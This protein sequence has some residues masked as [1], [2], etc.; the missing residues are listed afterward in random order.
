MGTNLIYG[1]NLWE[2]M[3][4]DDLKNVSRVEGAAGLEE[5]EPEARDLMIAS[6]KKEGARMLE[7]IHVRYSYRMHSLPEFFKGMLQRFTCWYNRENGRRGTLWE[8]RF[9]STVVGDGL[10][11]RTVAAYI[12]LNPVRAGM[13]EDPADYRWS[14]YGEAVSGGR[15]AARARAGLV[16]A[17]SKFAEEEP[18]ARAWAQG[19]VSKEYR[20]IL[21]SAGV[22]R[23][24]EIA[25]SGIK[26]RVVIRKGME[27][28]KAEA[29]LV[30]LKD[31]KARDLK[32][33]KVVRCRVRYF[34]EGGVIGS[35]EFVNEL[36]TMRRNLFSKKRKDGARRP[37]GSLKEMT[38]QIWAMRDLQIE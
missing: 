34:T 6:A 16:R 2:F 15:G 8:S 14:S 29:E 33:S 10:A 12:D 22:E 26:Q 24:E 17:L 11:A 5:Y 31:E 3:G 37:R 19:G 13:V 36:F 20:R 1:D 18:K 9:R 27:P 23:E 25:H 32:I 38:G 35:K 28:N 4:T 21:I 30:R 7:E